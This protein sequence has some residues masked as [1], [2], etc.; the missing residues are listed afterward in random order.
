MRDDLLALQFRLNAPKICDLKCL[1]SLNLSMNPIGMTGDTDVIFRLGARLRRMSELIGPLAIE[2]IGTLAIQM[3]GPLAISDVRP[4]RV[5]SLRFN[6]TLLHLEMN[7]CGL[8]EKE[9][10]VLR[11]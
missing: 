7:S 1:R 6:T 5:P 4:E 9:V 8:G 3:I 2:L 11:S 10:S